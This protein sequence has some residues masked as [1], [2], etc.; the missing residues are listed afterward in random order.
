MNPSDHPSDPIPNPQSIS[1]V[2]PMPGHYV[3]GH[4]KRKLLMIAYGTALFLFGLSQIWTPL[5][6]VTFGKRAKAEAIAVIKTKEGVPDL[7]LTDDAQIA[8]KL[9]PH[10]RSYIFWNEFRFHTDSGQPID[11]RAPVGSQLKPLY[12][13]TDADGLPTTDLV[14]Y[15]VAHPSKAVFPMIVSTWFAPGVLIVAGLGC[16]IIGSTLYYWAK[17]PIEL[18][19]IHTN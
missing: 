5:L 15:D 18:P 14:Y 6:L 10:D 16:M 1:D 4:A 19:H 7:T 17:R 12:N 3:P 13:L 11:V 9:E 8:N 2:F